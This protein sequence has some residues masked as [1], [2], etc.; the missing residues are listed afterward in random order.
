MSLEKR[1]HT[2]KAELD[3]Q[4]VLLVAVSKTY[5][6][7]RILELYRL[8]HRVF[9]ENRVQ[10]LQEKKAALPGDIQWHLIGHLQ[11]N[12]ARMAV[13][14]A[15]MIESV[16]SIKLLKLIQKEAQQARRE[17]E[18]L[19]QVKIASEET[20]YGFDPEDLL[21]ALT[22]ALLSG[23]DHVRIRGVMGMAS[24]VEDPEQVRQEFRLLGEVFTKLKTGPLKAHPGF[25]QISM[26]MSGDYKIAI[27]E[28]STMVRIGSLL[29]GV[30]T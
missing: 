23:M 24:F 7:E 2:L 27:Q 10:E 30:R 13:E 12:K 15:F 19:L 26:G 25:D 22:P 8:G 20:K 6:A 16:D 1:Y 28:G 29:F 3:A 11:S 21:S 9:G 17:I 14:S 5:P 4:D 18:V